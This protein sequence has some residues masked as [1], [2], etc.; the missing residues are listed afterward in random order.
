M[1]K[2]FH[3]FRLF[4][5]RGKSN[6]SIG[7]NY[8]ATWYLLSDAQMFLWYFCISLVIAAG[9][10]FYFQKSI[11]FENRKRSKVL[12][13]IQ[14]CIDNSSSPLA[15]VYSDGEILYANK[16]FR[17]LA[18]RNLENIFSFFDKNSVARSRYSAEQAIQSRLSWLGVVKTG[19]DRRL[20]QANCLCTITPIKKQKSYLLVQL[21]KLENNT[22]KISEGSRHCKNFQQL[23]K[24]G[25]KKQL[26]SWNSEKTRPYSYSVMMIEIDQFSYFRSELDDAHCKLI[27]QT[28]IIRITAKLPQESIVCCL[29][30]DEIFILIWHKAEIINMKSFAKKVQD[31]LEAAVDIEGKLLYFSANI[32]ISGR[33]DS[34][35]EELV[36][37][38]R[39]ALHE[40]KN[41]GPACY[42]TFYPNPINLEHHP[43]FQQ[44]KLKRGIEKLEFTVH[45]QAKVDLRSSQPVGS[46]ALIRWSPRNTVA[47]SPEEFIPLA[48]RTGLISKIGRI[49]LEQVCAQLDRW[50]NEG[51]DQFA[52]ALNVSPFQLQNTDFIE[53]L[54]STLNFYDFD[55]Q[56]LEFEVTESLLLRNPKAA[57]ESLSELRALGHKIYIDDFGTGYSSLSY[58]ADL[59]VDCVK[60]DRSFIRQIPS[61]RRHM[62]IVETI[63]QLAQQLGIEV[64]AEG[65][66]TLAQCDALK[67]AGCHI[68]QGFLYGKAVPA[69]VFTQQYLQNNGLEKGARRYLL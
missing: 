51:A 44:A 52:V 43:V 7:L 61:D 59:P 40:A 38:S 47:L 23:D 13:E 5:K 55:R 32:G 3:I 18:S 34:I 69:K 17:E 29:E 27:L 66:E 11:L 57:I 56:L 53:Q 26:K 35:D 49:V 63:V 64:V 16:D 65:V 9:F 31:A 50:A 8:F 67:R 48:E 54:N 12:E 6:P 37:Q 68:G 1:S 19:E 4:R 62:H 28:L 25:L 24:S 41:I 20:E 60:I 39:Q 45:Y 33:S 21:D 46:E 14:L 42:A 15:V 36:Y 58:L 22:I 30:S 10:I 2:L